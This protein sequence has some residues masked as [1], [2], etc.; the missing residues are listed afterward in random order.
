MIED[1]SVLAHALGQLAAGLVGLLQAECSTETE[2][3]SS[4]LQ[5]LARHMWILR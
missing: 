3:L 5:L 4:C 2:M 1:Q